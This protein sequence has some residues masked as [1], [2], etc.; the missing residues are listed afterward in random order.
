MIEMIRIY[1]L[2]VYAHRVRC[3]RC[4]GCRVLVRG[5]NSFIGKE[6]YKHGRL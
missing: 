3:E 6:Q 5:E 2:F 4:V 1:E